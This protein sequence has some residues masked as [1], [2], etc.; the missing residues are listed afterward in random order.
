MILAM[1]NNMDKML[2]LLLENPRAV[3]NSGVAIPCALLSAMNVDD[4]ENS[5]LEN[6]TRAPLQL[7]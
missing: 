5:G 4:D 3:L 7:A 6:I 1:L 2:S